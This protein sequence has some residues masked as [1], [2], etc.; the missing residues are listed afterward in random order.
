[1][2]R[3][4]V[5]VL[6]A[7]ALIV[8]GC[9]SGG[10]RGDSTE[11]GSPIASATQT[12][13]PAGSGSLFVAGPKGEA[14]RYP[15]QADGTVGSRSA[16]LPWESGREAEATLL[17]DA[18]DGLALTSTVE[19]PLTDVSGTTALQVRD[20]ATG[21]VRRALDVDG[22]CSGPD[23]ASYPCLLLDE[24]RIVRT[25]PIDDESRG[26]IT[27]SSLSTGETLAEYG[28]FEALADVRP[29][30][31]ADA[32]VVVTFDGDA[33]AHAYRTLDTRTGATTL[34]GRIPTNQSGL[35]VL[36]TDSVLTY[37]GA[38]LRTIG[39][40]SVAAVEVPELGDRGPG[41]EGCSADGRYLYLRGSGAAE[42]H[43]DEPIQLVAITLANG[44]RRSVLT[45]DEPASWIM[46][47][48]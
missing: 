44:S 42:V 3:V 19:L 11:S 32:L 5:A 7:A 30:S 27:I 28:P 22:W 33:A 24:H 23:G 12:A 6:A 45:I 41:V 4:W 47:T 29:T 16:I 9:A 21:E 31:S 17:K 48:R 37:D 34:I 25:T 18:L 2:R 38:A 43:A 36:G 14:V 10:S 39:P 8:T 1:M 13:V 35:C 20:V 40:A 26:T 46:V 15:I